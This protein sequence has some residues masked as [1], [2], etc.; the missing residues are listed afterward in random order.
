MAKRL[1]IFCVFLLVLGT[2]AL[3]QSH[4][5]PSA[6]LKY[7]EAKTI[8]LKQVFQTTRDWHVTAYKPQGEDPETGDLAVK[9][10][11]WFDLSNRDQACRPILDRGYPHQNLYVVQ[12]DEAYIGGYT[13]AISAYRNIC[14]I[15]TLPGR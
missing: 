3:P 7:V 13:I 8:P 6:E 9:I 1:A 10:C 11:F 2:S 14:S 12:K 15:T 5:T 4:E